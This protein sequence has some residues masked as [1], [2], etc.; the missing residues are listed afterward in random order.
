MP[1]GVGSPNEVLRFLVFADGADPVED[2]RAGVEA[3]LTYSVSAGVVGDEV[4]DTVS[5]HSVGAMV[6]SGEEVLSGQA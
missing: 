2:N 1:G 4:A 5:M 6:K 3:M